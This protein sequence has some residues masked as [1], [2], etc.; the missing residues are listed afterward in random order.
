M[1]RMPSYQQRGPAGVMPAQARMRSGSVEGVSAKYRCSKCM[2]DYDVIT[3]DK[4]SCPMCA[5]E[6]ENKRLYLKLEEAGQQ[7]YGLEQRMAQ[8]ASHVDH[9]VAIREALAIVGSEDMAWL[10]GVLYRYR[11][12]RSLTLLVMTS[13]NAAR[14]KSRMHDIFVLTER[15]KDNEEYRPTSPG[16]VAI[17]GYY[18][19]IT[20]ELGSKQAM[21]YLLRAMSQTLTGGG[22]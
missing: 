2:I 21:S 17:L 8:L 4:A 1:A 15:G 18:D 5:L 12:D 19:E 9:V 13:R 3:G 20:R 22:F 10:K 14:A 6:K 11:E 16:G 7:I